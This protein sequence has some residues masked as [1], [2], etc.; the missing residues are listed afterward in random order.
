[1]NR[2]LLCEMP[3]FN[4]ETKAPSE[5]AMQGALTAVA[6]MTPP[7]TEGQ[8]VHQITEKGGYF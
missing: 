5:R 7:H 4:G 2:G 1:M 8:T 6:V 3:Q